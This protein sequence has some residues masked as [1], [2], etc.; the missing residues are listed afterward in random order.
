MISK[1]LGSINCDALCAR[2]TALRD[3]LCCALTLPSAEKAYA[4]SD[5]VGGR[6]YHATITFD[7]GKIWLAR[8]RLPNHNAPATEEGNFDRRS[9]FTTYRFLATTSIPVPEV[10]D[11]AD[12]GDVSNAVGAGYILL[13]KLPG[14]PMTWYAATEEQKETFSR[15]LADIYIE[16]DR[17]PFE[18]LGR[19]Q[20]G[21]NADSI[22]IGPAFFNYD[23]AGKASP[24]GP[25]EQSSDYYR[26]LVDR[27]LNLMKTRE[28]ATSTPVDLYLVYQ[29]LLD[30]LPPQSENSSPFFLR[31]MD[32]RDVNF[33]VDEEYTITGVIDWELAILA[34]KSSAFQSP[35]LMF[36]PGHI[37]EKGLL[38]PSEE[39]SRFC[40]I[41]SEE[42][43][44]GDLS[45]LTAQKLHFGFEQCTDI[46]PS[47]CFFVETVGSW[48]KAMT[49]TETFDWES[50]RKEAL[51]NTVMGVWSE[52]WT[53]C[54][55]SLETRRQ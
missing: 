54:C 7:D 28:I 46:V 47:D 2:A 18:K 10:H 53:N 51:E 21:L 55:C 3:G 16:L 24:C 11:Y 27:G 17:H 30:H 52:G 6:N 45:A 34:P 19:L 12:D 25:F 39:E 8:F 41:L 26:I 40:R 35:L 32:T 4:N 42:K 43:G 44:R 9:E 22:E 5:I 36:N 49:G 1:L 48:W 38:T 23:P 31:H 50:W 37:V 33:L 29:A 13:E 14:K 15:Q 20:P